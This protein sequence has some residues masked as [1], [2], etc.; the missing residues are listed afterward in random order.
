M[1]GAVVVQAEVEGLWVIPW[2]KAVIRVLGFLHLPARWRVYVA[3]AALHQMRLKVTAGGRTTVLRVS[4]L[5]R[6]RAG[7]E[8]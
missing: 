8:R 1:S 3:N 6:F 7:G 2:A 5:G 4:D